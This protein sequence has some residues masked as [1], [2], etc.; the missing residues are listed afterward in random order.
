MQGVTLLH[1]STGQPWQE[2][3]T[4]LGSAGRFVFVV[5]SCCDNGLTVRSFDVAG[6]YEVVV[7]GVNTDQFRI[8]PCMRNFLPNVRR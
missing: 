3:A 8:D 1:R 5:E 2:V 4:V 6:N 7:E